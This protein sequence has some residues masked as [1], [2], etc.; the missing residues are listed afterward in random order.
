M[1]IYGLFVNR[2]WIPSDG[3]S[4]RKAQEKWKYDE[5]VEWSPQKGSGKQFDSQILLSELLPLEYLFDSLLILSIL[6]R[7]LRFPSYS[8]KLKELT[9]RLLTIDDIPNLSYLPHQNKMFIGSRSLASIFAW[10]PYF[11]YYS[12]ESTQRPDRSNKKPLRRQLGLSPTLH[13]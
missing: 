2:F 11:S 4:T 12:G 3:M 1:F 8:P 5:I 7:F 10:F 6:P 9:E 13:S